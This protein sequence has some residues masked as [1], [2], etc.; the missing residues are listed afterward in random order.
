MYLLK[1]HYF[2]GIKP[3]TKRTI[4]QKNWPEIM[5][6]DSQNMC[7]GRKTIP[8]ICEDCTVIMGFAE[9][10]GHGQM[11]IVRNSVLQTW[12]NQLGT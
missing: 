1:L 11:Q 2:Y 8:S 9:I 10:A 4:G 7:Y 12:E 5:D 6:Y 3:K